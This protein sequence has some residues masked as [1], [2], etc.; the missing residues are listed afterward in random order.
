M[1][2]ISWAL[3]ATIAICVVGHIGA[4][5]LMKRNEATEARNC[6]DLCNLCNCVGFYCGDECI[7]ECNHKD[8]ESESS[9]ENSSRNLL[10]N[11]VYF[12]FVS[13]V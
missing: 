1:N 3:C 4:S 5:P 6:K 9:C 2:Q 7:C 13:F 12:V 10:F 11:L 8:D